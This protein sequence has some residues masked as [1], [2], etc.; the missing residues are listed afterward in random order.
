MIAEHAA[1]LL[2]KIRTVTA[3]ASATSMTIGGRSSDPGMVKIPLPACWLT[4]ARDDNDVQSY[5]RGEP[6]GLVGP[7]TVLGTYALTVMLPYVSEDDLLTVQFP[8]LEA[9]VN[10]VHGTAAPGG[11]QW[12]FLRQVISNVYPDRLAY[13]QRYTASYIHQPAIVP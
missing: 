4:F 9:I 1:D 2:A 12:R 3:L 8:T 13:E 11:F 6:S 10:A 5:E 7:C